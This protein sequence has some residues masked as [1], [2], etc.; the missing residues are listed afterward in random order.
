MA[1]DGTDGRAHLVDRAFAVAVV[2]AGV[3]LV[4]AGAGGWFMFDDWM[5]LGSRRDVLADDGV[6]AY[7]FRS[8]N[9]HLMAVAIAVQ[10]RMVALF[11]LATYLP[12]MVVIA[13]AH[14]GIAVVVRRILV[15]LGVRRPLASAS[16]VLLLFWG[17]AAG[18]LLWGLDAWFPLAVGMWLTHLLLVWHDGAPNRRDVLGVG[19]GTLAIASHSV[20]VVGAPVLVAMLAASRRWKAA[21]IAAIPLVP[22]MLWFATYRQQPA[23]YLH[24]AGELDPPVFRTE[25]LGRQLEFARVM[26]S[27][28][29]HALLPRLAGL[30]VLLVAV[31]VV[32]WRDARR[33]DERRPVL[34]ALLLFAVLFAASTAHAR[35]SG[36]LDY[37]ET[38]RY[39]AV[40]TLLLLPFCALA[41]QRAADVVRDGLGRWLGA[42]V[43]VVVVLVVGVAN[44]RSFLDERREIRTYMDAAHHEIEVLAAQPDLDEL[45]GRARVGLGF[46]DLSV[47]HV[48]R[49]VEQGLLP[50]DAKLDPL[51]LRLQ[52]ERIVEE[53]G[54]S[55]TTT[56]T[57]TTTTTTTT[58]LVTTT[59][60]AVVPP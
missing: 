33:D 39:V 4:V 8:H 20:A 50:T 10:H 55:T 46:W 24:V 25:S 22:Y 17:P 52:R 51:S 36:G 15:R 53:S 3:L 1:G 57:S 27:G 47:R 2:A 13:A 7:L 44:A 6:A 56:S 21:L 41:L 35:A 34:G 16:A 40:M 60:P 43:L 59:V 48:R 42:A 23:V 12:T 30:V 26:W 45:P 18:S 28:P 54:I 19:L 37:A 5:L 38:W 9:D 11:G 49:L 32:W 29:L 31:A 14:V 58:T